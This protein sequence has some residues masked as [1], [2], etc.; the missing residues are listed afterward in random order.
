MPLYV[1]GLCE[2]VN[3]APGRSSW[4]EAKYSRSVEPRPAITTSSPAVVTPSANAPASS[5]DDSRMS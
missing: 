3:I 4:P 2:A 1:A 5:G